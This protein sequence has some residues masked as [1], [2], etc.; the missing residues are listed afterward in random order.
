MRDRNM[1]VRER[2]LAIRREMDRRGISLKA[3]SFDSGISY[4]TIVSYFPADSDKL[5]ATINAAAIFMLLEGVD[6]KG[7]A[8]PLDLLSELLPAGFAMIRQPEGVDYDAV[9]EM[10]A[11]FVAEKNRA[12]HPDSEA[13]RDIGPGEQERLSTKVVQLVGSIAA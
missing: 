12:H 11:D 10:A 2:Q 3:V 9:C 13:G 4:A 7:P 1:I 6:R 5:P 8:L